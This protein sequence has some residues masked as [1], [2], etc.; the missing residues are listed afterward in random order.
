MIQVNELRIGNKVIDS[1]TNIICE[2]SSINHEGNLRLFCKGGSV[3]AN[4]TEVESIPLTKDILLECGFENIPST[5]CFRLKN[6]ICDIIIYPSG[7]IELWTDVDSIKINTNINK[8]H[9]LQNIY[10]SLIKTELLF[11]V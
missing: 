5:Q 9:E 6:N 2:I 1:Q 3:G 11:N 8:L 4:C 7:S 10:Y